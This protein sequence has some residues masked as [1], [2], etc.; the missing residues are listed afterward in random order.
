M[1]G[2]LS[3]MDR[4]A[5]DAI[6]DRVNWSTLKAM[7]RS[8][9]HYRHGLD[10]PRADTP[11]LAMGRAT[12]VAVLEPHLFMAEHVV[13]KGGRRQGGAWDEFRAEHHDREI[14]TEEEAAKCLAI[15]RAVLTNH[16]ASRYVTGGKAEVTALWT[17]EE[18]AM[19]GLSGYSIPCKARLDY[20]RPDV[21]VDLKTTRDASPDAF[22]RTTWNFQYH[23]QSAWYRDAHAAAKGYELPFVIIAVETEAPYAV[24]VYR[25]PEH[26][27]E[28]G[29]ETYRALLSR[30]DWCRKHD[31]WPGYSDDGEMELTLPRW[32]ADFGDE[33]ENIAGLDLVV[34]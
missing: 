15:Q 32:A 8:P 26:I 31:D 4:A 33:S 2:I 1:N 3:S 28:L 9:Q 21:L 7:G 25:V 12:H 27:L 16:P 22:G 19:G 10:N 14:L 6:T 13:W 29:R 11:S 17:E 23:V 34:G 24:Q 18:P 30:L 5:Y 20:V